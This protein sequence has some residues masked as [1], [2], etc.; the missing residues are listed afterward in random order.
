MMRGSNDCTLRKAKL[1]YRIFFLQLTAF[2]ETLT[3]SQRSL[4]LKFEEKQSGFERWILLAA[5]SQSILIGPS[6]LD[7]DFAYSSSSS[8][9]HFELA[10]CRKSIGVS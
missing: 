2:T 7:S 4:M 5:K 8:H 3:D 1:S 9:F 10:N 6:H